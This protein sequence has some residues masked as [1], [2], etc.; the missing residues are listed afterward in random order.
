MNKKSRKY[1][2][3]LRDLGGLLLD[4]EK[5]SR[6]S[7]GEYGRLANTEAG[8]Q[9][10]IAFP[11]LYEIGMSNQALRILYNRL[12][13]IQGISCD[14]AFAVAPD[15]ERVLRS[16]NLPIYG[17]DTGISLKDTD[18]L[19]FT[20]GYEL[21]AGGMLA[22]MDISDIPIHSNDRNDTDPVVIAGGPAVS[23]PLPYSPFIDAF[24]I[25]EAEAGFFDLAA[26][27]GK[28]KQNGKT[29]RDLLNYISAHPHI[30]VKGKEKTVRAIDMNFGMEHREAA[31]YPVSSMKTVQHHGALEIMRGCP[32]GCRFCHAGY[33]YRPMRQK[34]H[35]A[36]I[37]EAASFINNGGYRE[38]SL[39]SLSSGDFSDITGLVESLNR[40]YDGRHISFQMP[41]L[42]VSGFSLSVLEQISQ[43]RKSGLTFAIETP[44]DAWQMSINKDV[45]RNSVVEIIAEAK[46]HGWRGAKFYFMIG[47]PLDIPELPPGS[48]GSEEKEIVDF[49]MYVAGLT[50]MNFNINVGIF[51]P[52]PHTPYQR[53]AQLETERAYAKLMFIKKTLKTKGHKVTVSD[54]LIS[55]IEGLLSR[56]DDRVGDILEEAYRSGSRLDAWSEY[57]NQDIWKNILLKNRELA[58]NLLGEKPVSEPLPWHGI[59]SRVTEHYLRNEYSRSKKQKITSPCNTSCPHLCGVCNSIC[60]TGIPDVIQSF[61]T[62]LDARR[63]HQEKLHNADPAV[64]RLLFSFRKQGSAVFHSH[65]GLLEI[66]SM[67]LNRTGLPVMYTRG[68]N[69]LIKIEIASPLST[70]ITALAEIACLEFKEEITPEN[71]IE[72][73]NRYLPEGIGINEAELFRIPGGHKK[74]SL[75]SLLWGFSY[76]GINGEEFVP[77][78]QE[79]KYRQSI[80]TG[81]FYLKRN[82][83]LAKTQSP[84]VTAGTG[85]S[86][87]THREWTSYFDVYR[88]I[89]A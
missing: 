72:K 41:S 8:F 26:E 22:M 81:N 33:W 62:H 10:L 32:N 18:M 78:N 80:N 47:L 54:T 66:F 28:Q 51:I 88:D 6:Y 64:W 11:D 27:L 37:R 56:G 23:N 1:V 44:Q 12:N 31:V 7:G 75:A 57:I 63:D 42:K 55:A 67:T 14:R 16:K 39:S 49:V 61:S 36:V 29:R 89:Y 25:G 34:S 4:V 85:N 87:D 15:F 52:K 35:E 45:N 30:W 20:L 24:W 43:T 60:N 70:G 76:S 5:P 3:P 83:V 9:M 73:M 74:H 77:A 17:L 84:A 68:F 13:E 65:L 21:C 53:A 19:M 58:D 59:E 71:F 40:E 46:K 48:P 38:I 2:Y 50:R 69:P 82:S 86:S 79:K